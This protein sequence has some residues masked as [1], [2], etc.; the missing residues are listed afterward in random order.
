M[1][2]IFAENAF[3]GHYAEKTLMKNIDVII[4]IVT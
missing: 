4:L 1:K 3:G 2:I